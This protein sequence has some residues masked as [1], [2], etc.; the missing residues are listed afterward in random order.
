MLVAGVA[1]GAFISGSQL[2]MDQTAS[3]PVSTATVQANALLKFTPEFAPV[4][5]GKTSMRPDENRELLSSV[6]KLLRAYYVEPITAERETSMAR[7]TVKGMLSA[8]ADPDSHFLDPTER[9]LMEDAAS[10][11]FHGIGAILAFKNE[12]LNGVDVLKLVVVA[13]MPGG[14]ADTAGLRSGD[15][16]TH[17]DGKWV[18]THNPL[19]TPEMKRLARGYI[20]KEI[21]EAELRKA[22]DTAAKMLKNGTNLGDALEVLTGKT[23]GTTKLTVERSGTT[24]PITYEKVQL[25]NTVVDSVASKMLGRGV[26]Y[27]RISQF[28]TKAV[29]E[30]TAQL[31]KAMKSTNKP[32]GIVLDLRNNPGGLMESANTITAKMTGGGIFATIQEKGQQKVIKSAKIQRLGMPV[33]VLVN[34]GTASVAEIVAGNLRE[35]ISATIVGAKTFG[36]GMAQTPLFL[37]DGSEAVFTTGRMLTSKGYDFNGKGIIP[38]KVVDA[39]EKRHGDVQLSEAEKI[40]QSKLG[41]I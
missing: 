5:L 39:K 1:G 7:G 38:D 22:S 26:M 8:L 6:V 15:V 24:T 30:F 25:R 17:V 41:R 35:N 36:D 34:G 29:A 9:K 32:K 11:R 27:V 40:L 33:T 12:K 13:P 23:M 18:I 37:R 16:I 3:V 31:N 19:D 2:R 28:N 21:K 14:P 10:G 20:N 4:S